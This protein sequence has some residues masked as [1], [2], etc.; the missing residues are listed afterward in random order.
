[1]LW[2]MWAVFCPTSFAKLNEKEEE[3]DIFR[4]LQISSGNYQMTRDED[5]NKN[6][7]IYLSV[8]Q[9]FI[10]SRKTTAYYKKKEL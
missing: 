4:I 7:V 10:F 9:P 8:K 6:N 3:Y 1:M 2:R 5:C